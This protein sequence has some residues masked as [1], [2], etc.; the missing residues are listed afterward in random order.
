MKITIEFELDDSWEAY[1]SNDEEM[2]YDIIG[3]HDGVIYKI[4]E[5]DRKI[6]QNDKN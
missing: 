1:Y 4:I 3:E 2:I 5:S 6:I